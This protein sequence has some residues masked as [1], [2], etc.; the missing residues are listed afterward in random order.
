MQPA[1]NVPHESPRESTEQ[2]F[3]N[4]DAHLG[5]ILKSSV[6]ISIGDKKTIK[7]A[8]I[9]EGTVQEE[10]EKD[11]STSA[12]RIQE[13]TEVLKSKTIAIGGE[14]RV[15]LS[16]IESADEDQK[17]NVI[18]KL[19]KK[20]AKLNEVI[21]L[22]RE[23]KQCSIKSW[24]VLNLL[25]PSK[26][27]IDE[28][29]KTFGY[30]EQQLRSYKSQLWEHLGDDLDF[31]GQGVSGSMSRLSSVSDSSDRTASP[32]Q[33]SDESVQE[34]LPKAPFPPP[35][36]P[37]PP[38]LSAHAQPIAGPSKPKAASQA[39]ESPVFNVREFHHPYFTDF[40]LAKEDLGLYNDSY[41]F[42]MNEQKR[43]EAV[44]FYNGQNY[45][46]GKAQAFGRAPDFKEKEVWTAKVLDQYAL[47]RKFSME[48][49]AM[50]SQSLGAAA[51]SR[52]ASAPGVTPP[53]PPPPPPSSAP[54]AAPSLPTAG[55]S[56]S[57]RPKKKMPAPLQ[58][59]ADAAA[60]KR[61]HV[62]VEYDTA[63]KTL[64]KLLF[65]YPNMRIGPASAEEAA[66]AKDVY[67]VSEDE[68][69]TIMGQFEKDASDPTLG[70]MTVSKMV[71]RASTESEEEKELKIAIRG[72]KDKLMRAD[73]AL[74]EAE[75]NLAKLTEDCNEQIKKLNEIKLLPNDSLTVMLT[76]SLAI[77]EA[78]ELLQIAHRNLQEKKTT[79]EEEVKKLEQDYEEK[80]KELLKLL[81]EG[82][83]LQH[84]QLI[85]L[86]NAKLSPPKKGSE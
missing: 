84:R 11:K 74:T 30:I 54:R 34:T 14:I 60:I 50:T 83:N 71:K 9:L 70:K 4:I 15:A 32:I 19:D 86:A 53:P 46:M 21:N 39:K 47:Y 22:A 67:F 1:S 78:Q 61:A 13:F 18:V 43:E 37:P 56:Q 58:L 62:V 81:P 52:T 20:L 2:I 23:I 25:R 44:N 49:N 3:G 5:E 80:R 59:K 29:L 77:T 45:E 51:S 79:F 16:D 33:P 66:S 41:F 40:T 17:R 6:G 57:S 31:Q 63:K 10:H 73:R 72:A 82:A 12:N 68:L 28:T 26:Q 42:N 64:E 38:P 35:P 75:D 36:P 48:Y 85:A 76:K 7:V 27:D 55:V 8:K 69:K 65:P 24:G